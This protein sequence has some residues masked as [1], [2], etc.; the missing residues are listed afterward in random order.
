M[1]GTKEDPHLTPE[2][3]RVL[4]SAISQCQDKP[5][6][7]H[8]HHPATVHSVPSPPGLRKTGVHQEEFCRCGMKRHVWL[9]T[10]KVD[11][12]AWQ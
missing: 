2:E 4:A 6:S 8:E 3:L 12:G 5:G 1:I 9:T 10:F 11:A 7:S